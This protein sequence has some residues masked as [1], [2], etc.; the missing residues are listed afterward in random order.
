MENA[1]FRKNRISLLGFKIIAIFMLGVLL[2]PFS[3][4]NANPTIPTEPNSPYHLWKYKPID[5]SKKFS[6][7]NEHSLKLDSNDHP[8]LTYGGNQLFYAWFDSA[9]WQYEIVD[10]SANSGLDA[11]L[12]LDQNDFVYIG[13]LNTSWPQTVNYAY[14]DA[15]GWHIQVADTSEYSAY[16]GLSFAMDE[17]SF[18]R[19]S[20]FV[21]GMR[22]VYIYKDAIGWHNQELGTFSNRSDEKTSLA[23][24][25]NGD[26]SIVIGTNSGL[27]YLKQTGTGWIIS[28]PLGEGTSGHTPSLVLDDEGYPHISYVAAAEN[29]QLFHA[30]QDLQGWH[31]E[32][33]VVEQDIN[34]TSLTFDSDNNLHIVF[35]NSF[36]GP[37]AAKHAYWDGAAWQVEVIE[38]DASQSDATISIGSNG[39]I[40]VSYLMGSRPALKFAQKVAGTWQV[41]TVD[42]VKEMRGAS[43]GMDEDG[44]SKVAYLYFY[45]DYAGSDLMFASQTDTGW[46]IQALDQGSKVLGTPSL[47]LDELGYAHISYMNGALNYLYQ[48]GSGWHAQVVDPD[49]AGSSVSYLALDNT[50]YPHI[51]YYSGYSDRMTKYVYQDETGWHFDTN[52]SNLLKTYETVNSLV[53]L[54]DGYPGITYRGYTENGSALEFAYQDAD[55]WHTEVIDGYVDLDIGESYV[56]TRTVIHPN[57]NIL[58]LYSKNYSSVAS[59]RLATKDLSEW[60]IQELGFWSS[61]GSVYGSPL[62]FELD[63]NGA[64]FI[65]YMLSYTRSQGWLFSHQLPSGDW[66]GQS[67]PLACPQMVLDQKDEVFMVC[68]QANG[69]LALADP[70]ISRVFLPIVKH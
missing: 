22:L 58:V 8:H 34:G 31:S 11:S 49:C 46:D 53:L 47:V 12:L 60:N 48:D 10:S 55:G 4:V 56:S 33:V 2:S 37:Q 26:A 29:D 45:Y 15:S 69:S 20:V 64:A 35:S 59:L 1:M 66:Q 44:Y 6:A 70:N 67:L 61:L 16:S 42:C 36:Y 41:E 28:Q 19:F 50:G 13:Y 51:S 52:L 5:Q 63:S 43:F 38:G 9:A 21:S 24:D 62:D 14:K 18:P 3:A 40:G 57:G 39:Q 7:L 68:Y 65:L 30:Y 32:P 25:E 54:P 27:T 17:S 23:I